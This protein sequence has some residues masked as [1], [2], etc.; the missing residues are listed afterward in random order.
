MKICYTLAA[1]GL[2]LFGASCSHDTVK[3]SPRKYNAVST[4][5][6]RRPNDKAKFKKNRGEGLGI[7]LNARNPYKASTTNAPKKY[8]YNNN[9]RS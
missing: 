9:P 4:Q 8:K 3:Q 1:C 7:D 2:L 6:V 5:S